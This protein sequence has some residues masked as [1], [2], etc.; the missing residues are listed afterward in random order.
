MVPQF[1]VDGLDFLEC[2]RNCEQLES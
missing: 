2:G 1:C